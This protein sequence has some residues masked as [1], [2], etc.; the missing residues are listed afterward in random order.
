MDDVEDHVHSEPSV[1]FFSQSE[2]FT[3]V[4]KRHSRLVPRM[5]FNS[6][7]LKVHNLF[8]RR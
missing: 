2:D 3:S 8:T 5:Q 4:T 1:A 6:N 7:Y